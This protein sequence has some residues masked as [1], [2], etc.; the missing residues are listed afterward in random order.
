MEITTKPG[1]DK[2]H[3]AAF[4][5]DSDAIFNATDPF[6]V[7]ATPAGKQRYGFELSGPIIAKKTDFSLALER[8]NIDEF[9][10]VNART[11]GPNND[12]GPDG[13]GFPLQETVA[14]PPTALDRLGTWRLAGKS[15]GCGDSFL[16]GQRQQSWQ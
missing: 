1:A 8:R 3:G 5:T 4:F 9:N 12:I 10:V 11:L 2:F 16:R 15:Q 7:T 13:N 14:A 6:S